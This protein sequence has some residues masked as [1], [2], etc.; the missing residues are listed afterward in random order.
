MKKTTNQNNKNMPSFKITLSNPTR[1]RKA[2]LKNGWVIFTRNKQTYVVEKIQGFG[3]AF[4]DR[5]NGVVRPA[6]QWRADMTSKVSDKD[7]IVLVAQP[8]DMRSYIE[9]RF[10]EFIVVYDEKETSSNHTPL[11]A[12]GETEFGKKV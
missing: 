1:F 4:V 2:F 5:K 9:N 6:T 3:T 11:K 7:D 10:N 12:V 8:A